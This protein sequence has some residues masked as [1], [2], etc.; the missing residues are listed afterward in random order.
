MGFL[1]G[2]T[3]ETLVSGCSALQGLTVTFTVTEDLVTIGDVG[4]GFQVNTYPTGGQV[5]Q[6]QPLN[7]FQYPI[8]VSGGDVTWFVPEYWDTVNFVDSG[9]TFSQPWPTGYT[10][11]P[12]NTTM[13]LPVI[14]D[15]SGGLSLASVASNRVLA[16]S[17]LQVVLTTDSGN[18]TQ[19]TYNY[20][21]P[22]GQLSTHTYSFG[23]GQQFSIYGIQGVIV[24]NDNGAPTSF[25]SGAGTLTYEVS[26]GSLTLESASTP[27]AGNGEPGTAED[28]NAIYGDFIGTGTSTVTQSVSVVPT[29]MSFVFGQSTFGKDEVTST[30]NWNPAYYLQVTGFPNTALGFNAPSDLTTTPSPRPTVTLELDDALNQDLSSSQR[31]TIRNNLPS[32]NVPVTPIVATDSTLATNYQTFLYP[33]N[34]SFPNTDAFTVLSGDDVAYLTINATLTVPVAT[35]GDDNATQTFTNVTVNASALIELAAGEDPRMTDLNPTAP[36]SYPSWLSYDLRI[37]SVTAGQTHDMFSVPS[38]EDA[39]HAIPY[40]Q[41]VLSNLNNPSSITNG[42]TFDNALTQNE[43][44]S[45]V[46]WLPTPS[47]Q[48]EELSFAIARVRITSGVDEEIGP[49]R[50][51]FRLFNAASTVTNFTEV[52][53]GFGTYR[54]GSD[55]SAGHKIPLLGVELGLPLSEYVTVPCFATERVN[56]SGPADMKTQ[57]DLPN[58]VSI[59][60]SAGHEVDTF[61]GCW[62][63]VNQTNKFLPS[64]PPLDPSDWDGPWNGTES[65]NGAIAVSPHQ[66]LV[67]EIRFDGAPVPPGADTGTTDKLA[68]RN[69]AWLGAQP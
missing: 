33:Y 26:S 11:N 41:Q 5:A 32:V 61:F 23:S 10:P 30:P 62:L 50:V 43:E 66:C 47:G 58:A 1:S 38:P 27:C 20:T 64:F 40:I 13:A 21:D 36:L 37:F 39:A 8:V 12:A 6:S 24:G 15:D 59:T 22:G 65:L 68:Q 54:W 29:S 7:W 46:A 52:G 3:T 45:A 56:L 44:D 28:S 60:T 57:K 18:V 48:A 49:V 55:G 14:P 25:T 17:I 4:F 51:F 16:G 9:P 19:A 63:D 67:A 31:Q 2:N 34:I 69:I 53:T 35:G 42:D